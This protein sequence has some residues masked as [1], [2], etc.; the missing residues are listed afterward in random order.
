MNVTRYGK[1]VIFGYFSDDPVY[2]TYEVILECFL[3]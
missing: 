3:I 1:L 2:K